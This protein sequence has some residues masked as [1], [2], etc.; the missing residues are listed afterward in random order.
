MP[1]SRHHQA[2]SEQGI[3]VRFQKKASSDE[4]VARIRDSVRQTELSL[5][6]VFR[7]GD[8]VYPEG[9]NP[10][11]NPVRS[12]SSW[13]VELFLRSGVLYAGSHLEVFLARAKFFLECGIELEPGGIRRRPL[14]EEVER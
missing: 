1:E 4:V 11:R 6:K 13:R 5:L 7:D 10:G 3:A 9:R 12:T 14:R 8:C 2:R